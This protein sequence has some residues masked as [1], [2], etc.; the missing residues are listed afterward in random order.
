MATSAG[1]PGGLRT[2]HHK[3]HKPK[4]NQ[5]LAFMQATLNWTNPTTWAIAVVLLALP[6]V[7]IRFV[8][9]NNSLPTARK[10][11][12]G[13]LN[14]LLWLLLVSYFLQLR[15]PV[16]QPTRHALLVGDEVPSAVARQ[17][18]DS[19]RIQDI[20][21]SRNFKPDYDSVTLVGQRFPTEILTQLS[22]ASIQWI[23]YD[24]PDQLQTI[25]WKGILRQGEMQRVTGRIWSSAAQPFQIRFGARTLD[26]ATLR[27]GANAFTFQ[28]PAFAHG[29]SQL[30]LVLGRSTTL[31]T[32]RFFTQV[33]EPLTVQFLLNNPD[34]ESKT[35]ADWLGKHGNTVQVSATLS[36]DIRSNVS[37]NKRSTVT[38]TPDLIITEPANAGNAAVRKAV[39]DGKA[40]LFINLTNPESDTR[41]INQV[42]GSHWQVRKT[43]NEPTVP[44][45]HGLMALPY[46]FADR[47]NQFAVA[48]YPVAVQQESGRV[49]V[50]LLSETFPLALSGDSLT[51]NQVWT[52]VL[53]RLS[54][55]D[56]NIV[57]VEAPLYRGMRQ[58]IQINNPVNR[59]RTL[60]AGKDT[61]T[62]LYSPI[63]DRSAEGTSAFR[64]AGWQPVQD[65]LAVYVNSD[66]T[67]DLLHDRQ[68]VS[69]FIKAHA[70]YSTAAES[71]VRVIMEQIPN[72]LW[73]VLILSCFTALWVEPKL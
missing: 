38:K 72:W 4:T 45:G 34:F 25:H 48:R 69:Q 47:V 11:L 37:I 44:I 13:G 68:L 14:L 56:K 31:D 66:T 15:W 19:L 54:T 52:A 41:T 20:F 7:Q 51:Y 60:T 42:L 21:S 67:G 5:H 1:P 59:L 71:S 61:M 6:V 2:S 18:K 28:F 35:L 36:K 22:K 40:V 73:L 27:K 32:I 24:K 49:G 63:N 26:S 65:S 23:P 33:T 58:A 64:L 30:E 29:R 3:A 10:W 62:L 17:V 46:R 53:A 55:P 43:S 39:A 50:S 16:D 57:Q 12:R 9:R 8:I 70:L